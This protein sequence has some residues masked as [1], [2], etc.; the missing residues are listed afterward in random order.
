MQ[1]DA[2]FIE[3]RLCGIYNCDRGGLG[4]IVEADHIRRVGFV[5]AIAMTLG[6]KYIA[7]ENRD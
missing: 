7:G 2:R 6:N 5:H 3:H 1:N 4:G